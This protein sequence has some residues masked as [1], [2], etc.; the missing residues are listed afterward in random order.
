MGGMGRRYKG[1]G[2]FWEI[3]AA[4]GRRS[5]LDRLWSRR[6]FHPDCACGEC[7]NLGEMAAESGVLSRQGKGT[8]SRLQLLFRNFEILKFLITLYIVFLFLF[9]DIYIKFL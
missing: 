9:I 7:N 6:L 2:K 5:A 8:K 3:K 1:H 4:A